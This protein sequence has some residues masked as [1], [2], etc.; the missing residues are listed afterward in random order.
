MTIAAVTGHTFLEFFVRQMGD[1]FREDEPASMHP[2]L[3][4]AM[5]IR[6]ARPFWPFWI[7]NRSRS[8][9]TPPATIERTYGMPQSTLPDTSDRN[10]CV[11]EEGT[12][13][14]RSQQDSERSCPL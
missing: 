1:Q 3:S 13:V 2:P 11:T 14:V 7:S 10:Y 6:S 12:V 9:T 4:T 8:K 5:P